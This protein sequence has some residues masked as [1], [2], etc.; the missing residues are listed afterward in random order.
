MKVHESCP[1]WSIWA[2]RTRDSYVQEGGVNYISLLLNTFG[3]NEN[4]E[5]LW[6]FH[7]RALQWWS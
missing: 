3:H 6:T 7:D 1:E 4:C 2:Y 5:I